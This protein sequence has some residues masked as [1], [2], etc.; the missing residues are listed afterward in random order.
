[1]EPHLVE[2]FRT[3]RNKAEE[4]ISPTWYASQQVLIQYDVRELLHLLYDVM[5]GLIMRGYR[6]RATRV[7]VRR[8]S[9]SYL[10]NLLVIVCVVFRSTGALIN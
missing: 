8:P 2:V 7:L 9:C 5:N 1:M 4:E 6:K 3:W 10:D